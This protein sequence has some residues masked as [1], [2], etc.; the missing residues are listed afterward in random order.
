MNPKFTDFIIKRTDLKAEEITPELRLAEDIGFYGMDAIAFLDDFFAEFGIKN[1]EDFD[2]DL[3]I[4]GGPDFT[5]R[6]LNWLKN[7]LIK[8]RRKYLR[9]D[10][11]L[12]HLESVIE[13]GE[14]F[15]EH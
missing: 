12:G 5:P 4:N 7:L 1:H 11:S 3:H 8:N 14:W 10:V 9:P 15:N 2:T 6:P 13:K